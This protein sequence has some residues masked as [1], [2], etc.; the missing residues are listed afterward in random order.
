MLGFSLATLLGTGVLATASA[1]DA[2]RPD[3]PASP[4][5]KTA[6]EGRTPEVATPDTPSPQ[7]GAM[8]G[9]VIGI[10]H[11]NGVAVVATPRG[12][13]ALRGSPQQLSEL[14]V[15]DRIELQPAEEPRNAPV[16]GLPRPGVSWL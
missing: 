16:P 4:D 1:E 6:V 11:D 15:G 10:D 8:I 9:A 13:I 5:E 14:K 2:A 7:P 3:G 12:L